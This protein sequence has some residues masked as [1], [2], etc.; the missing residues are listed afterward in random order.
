MKS[1]GKAF[2]Q[3]FNIMESNFLLMI[4]E[5]KPLQIAKETKSLV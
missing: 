5:G 1:D 2:R 4:F 3:D